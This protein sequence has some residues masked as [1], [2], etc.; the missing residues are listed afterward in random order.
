MEIDSASYYI[1]LGDFKKTIHFLDEEINKNPS[2]ELFISRGLAKIET[3]N[4]NEAL[5]DLKQSLK[6]NPQNDTSYYNIGYIFYL[7]EKY[8]ES[9]N[10]YDSALIYNGENIYY[11]IARGNSFLEL[12]N[13]N[14][15][16]KDYRKV[17][18]LDP[19]AD[20]GHYGIAMCH[21]YTENY[22]SAKYYLSFA[23][24]FDPFDP[25]YY[26]QRALCKYLE[27]DYEGALKDFNFSIDIDPDNVEARFS[28]ARLYIDYGFLE[29]ALE[30][31]NYALIEDSL[32]IELINERGNLL[33]NTGNYALAVE[34]F[35]SLINS[36][37]LIDVAYY[38]R[39]LSYFFLDHFV[40][41]IQ[42]FTKAIELNNQDEDYFIYRALS[43]QATEKTE[44]A[45]NDFLLALEINQGN[46]DIY[47]K[48]STVFYEV[49]DYQSAL[50]D[51]EKTFKLDPEFPLHCRKYRSIC[52]IPFQGLALPK[53]FQALK[54]AV[55]FKGC[56]K[57][58]V[59]LKPGLKNCLLRPRK[60]IIHLKE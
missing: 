41:A 6:L 18:S 34:D 5:L 60:N 57:L 24:T 20:L 25:D 30:D 26:Y 7:Q 37:D 15:A 13:F 46:P 22:D 23:L 40:R 11:L 3:N 48:R 1:A 59:N 51:L 36:D 10:Y 55:K 47:F 44:A 35:T 28:R 8:I 43:Q 53:C 31:L 42:D 19:E 21:F 29:D 50:K 39:G 14:L 4:L 38:N 45:F 52:V 16:L 9:V 27:E 12:D 58:I 17:I 49:E 32:N 54:N 33:L 2:S 56:L